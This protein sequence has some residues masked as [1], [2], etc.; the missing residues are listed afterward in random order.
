M[1]SGGR[2]SM[3]FT[4][5]QII[6]VW[7]LR[8]WTDLNPNGATS[9]NTDLVATKEGAARVLDRLTFTF[10]SVVIV[11]NGKTKS[12]RGT[13]RDDQSSHA[14]IYGIRRPILTKTTLGRSKFSLSSIKSPINSRLRAGPAAQGQWESFYEVESGGSQTRCTQSASFAIA[15]AAARPRSFSGPTNAFGVA[16]DFS[17]K[18]TAYIDRWQNVS[19]LAETRRPKEAEFNLTNAKRSGFWAKACS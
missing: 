5:T 16:Q 13:K 18:F 8:E 10:H 3:T 6:W 14:A 12:R 4:E 17:L 11:F 7:F 9:C 1:V 2:Y 15:M 19:A